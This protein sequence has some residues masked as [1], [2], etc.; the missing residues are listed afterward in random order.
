MTGDQYV[1]AILRK[2]AVNAAAAQSAAAGV[3]PAIQT[4]AGTQLAGLTA[5]NAERQKSVTVAEI[6]D[7]RCSR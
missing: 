5:R 6:C 7:W 1:A 4:W 3:A 2:Y